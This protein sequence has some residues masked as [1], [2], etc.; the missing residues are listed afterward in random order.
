MILAK[1]N[2]SLKENDN[3]KEKLSIAD[4]EVARLD[5]ESQEWQTRAES[6]SL[7]L[8]EARRRAET[9]VQDRAFVRDQIEDQVG[10]LIFPSS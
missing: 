7:E 1:H 8:S 9:Q 6:L 5:Q 4:E 2:K 10:Q 3:L